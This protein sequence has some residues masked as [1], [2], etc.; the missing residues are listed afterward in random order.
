[1]SVRFHQAA[2]GIGKT[3]GLTSF[4][5]HPASRSRKTRTGNGRRR[6]ALFTLRGGPLHI[7]R[8]FNSIAFAAASRLRNAETSLAINFFRLNGLMSSKPSAI[9]D[10][11]VAAPLG[12]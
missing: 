9:K 4:D 10:P 2:A 3:D 6:A 7:G 8:V 11:I 12:F 1:L 5:N